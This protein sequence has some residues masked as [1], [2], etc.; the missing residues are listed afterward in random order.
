MELTHSWGTTSRDFGR[1]LTLARNRAGLT[2]RDLAA[3]AKVPNGT[4]SGYLTGDHLPSLT[5]L[6]PFRRILAACGERGQE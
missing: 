4:V 6:E 2:V 1:E 5:Y 3:A